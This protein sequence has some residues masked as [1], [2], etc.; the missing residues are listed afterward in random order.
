MRGGEEIRTRAFDFAVRSVRLAD[1]LARKPG[2]G[3][4]LAS[5][6]L[7]AATSVGANLEEAQGAESRADFAHKL[8]I[9]LKEAREALWWLRVLAESGLLDKR[10]TGPITRDAEGIVRTMGAILASTKGKRRKATESP[11]PS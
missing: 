6:Y 9:S 8:S 2:A 10:Q 1:H 3:R 11:L 7:R 4:I 5:Q